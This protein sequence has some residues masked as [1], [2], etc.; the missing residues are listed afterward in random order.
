MC[1][2]ISGISWHTLFLVPS[3]RYT[4]NI[5]SYAKSR[6]K[7]GG[8]PMASIISRFI[9]EIPLH[10]LNDTLHQHMHTNTKIIRN[11]KSYI[12]EPSFSNTLNLIKGSIVEHK[13]FGRGEVI[14]IE[15]VGEHSKITI[16]FDMNMTKKFIFKYANLKL[17]K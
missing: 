12:D 16:L 11:K 1:I 8:M 3:L 15:G 5:L 10:L 2:A 7:F 17:I 14:N 13:I 4:A 9:K 6:R